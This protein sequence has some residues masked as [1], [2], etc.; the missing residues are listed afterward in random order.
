MAMTSGRALRMTAAAAA[1]AIGFFLL[2]FGGIYLSAGQG[3]SVAVIW[4]ATAFGMCML[5]RLS[6]NI[7]NDALLLGAV[8]IGDLL[9]NGLE[10]ASWPMNISYSLINVA[11]VAAGVVATR[12]FAVPR[13]RT[14]RATLGFAAVAGI[15]PALL[16]AS[17]AALVNALYGHPDWLTSGMQWFFANVLG[18][19]MLFPF[20]MTVSFRQ[21]ARQRLKQRLPELLAI[22]AGVIAVSIFVFRLSPYPLQFLALLAILVPTVR[23][24]FLGGGAALILVGAVALTAPDGFGATS[25]VA[26]IELLQLFLAV[27]SIVSVRAAIVLNQRDLHLALNRVRHARAVRASRFKSLL[28]SH[29]SHEARSPLSAII[30]FSSMLESGSLPAASAQEFAQIIAHNG[31][32]LQRLHDDLLDLSSAEAGKLSI[33]AERVPVADTLKNCVGAIRLETALGGK[34]V[35]LDLPE[36][37]L[38]VSADPGRLAQII[39]NLIANAY[40]Y[41]DNFSPITVRARRLEDGFG[42]IEIVNAGPGIPLRERQSV[43]QPF[44]RGEQSGRQVPGAGLGLSI[45][46]L[47]V[48]KQGGR[49]D[50]ESVPGRQTRFWVDLPLV[51]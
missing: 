19:S 41:G 23:F 48:E 10:G 6:R 12:R 5:L 26:R 33:K 31:E 16:S 29:V 1:T 39:N 38:A 27:C 7:Q 46:K 40:K 2:G 36:D 32:L 15:A 20:G 35:E 9:A 21:F 47:L 51:A 50:F 25:P 4:P 34:T 43:F 17:L 22:C 14:M 28:L 13:F 45:A 8:L 3:N 11:D 49:I 44:A 42:R 24:R 37:N 18:F 30:G